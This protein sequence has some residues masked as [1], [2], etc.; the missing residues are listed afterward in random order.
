MEDNY[1]FAKRK[2]ERVEQ[3]NKIFDSDSPIDDSSEEE[4]KSGEPIVKIVESTHDSL[5]DSVGDMIERN[6][7]NNRSNLSG[8]AGTSKVSTMAKSFHSGHESA[9]YRA[10]YESIDNFSSKE[11]DETKARQEIL[12]QAKK[13]LAEKTAMSKLVDQLKDK[14]RFLKAKLATL[15]DKNEHLQQ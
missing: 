4:T 6:T 13:V 10:L 5:N 14:K 2:L 9:N 11:T 7:P 3:D 12:Q 15:E 8:E 1:R